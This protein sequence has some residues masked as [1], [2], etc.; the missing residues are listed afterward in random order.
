MTYNSVELLESL[1]AEIQRILQNV[2]QLK[3]LDNKVLNTQPAP[4]KWSVAQVLEHLNSY[5][6]YYLPQIEKATGVA[7][8][9]AAPATTFKPGWLGDYF[10]KSM[11]SSV[12]TK[13]EITNKMKAPKDHQPAETLDSLKV[14]AEFEQGAKKL[15]ELLR[16]AKA[17]NISKVRV[18]ISIAK[19]IKISL[20][21]T[22]RF[23]IAHKTR[24]FLQLRNTLAAVQ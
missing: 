6:R 23:L 10:T 15:S 22:F 11:Y 8:A 20:G 24:H 5:N 3:Q 21:D 4:G 19:W 1:D 14:I 2:T 13:G 17:R 12:V 18:P 9:T 16:G 7:S